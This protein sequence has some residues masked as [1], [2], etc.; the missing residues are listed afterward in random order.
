MFENMKL[1]IK[2]SWQIYRKN[3]G[4]IAIAIAAIWIPLIVI[5][6]VLVDPSV[7]IDGMDEILQNQDLVGTPEYENAAAIMMRTSA[8]YMAATVLISFLGLVSDI[9]ITKIADRS[10]DSESYKADISFGDAFS[11]SVA[12]LPKVIWIVILTALFTA[13]G[14]MM[15]F[16]PGIYIYVMSSLAVTA[17]V[18][19]GVKGL[20]AIKLSFMVIKNE[21]FTIMAV[22]LLFIVINSFLLSGFEYLKVVLPDHKI[23]YS[24]INGFVMFIERFVQSF[25]LVMLTVFFVDRFKK[26]NNEHPQDK[27]PAAEL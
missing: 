27:D 5:Q 21:F 9:I 1:M 7:K 20:K 12:V 19:V 6:V 24:S 17:A 10:H 8:I 26:L 13:L 14:L 18:L 16:L 25:Q 22:I 2:E 4:K 15:F 3:F 23:V 11:D